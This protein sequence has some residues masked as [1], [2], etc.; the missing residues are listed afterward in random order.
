VIRLLILLALILPASAESGR[1]MTVKATGYCGGPCPICQTTGTT[2]DGS[3]TDA[4][5]Y[6]IAAHLRYL[7]LGTRLLITSGYGYL[8][9][10][11]PDR[12]FTV[13]DTGGL[14][15]HL[16]ESTPDLWI[17]LRFRSHASAR[18]WGVRTISVFVFDQTNN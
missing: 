7:P 6:G 17:D 12:V 10:S 5:P 4:S 16:S 3:A 13:D 1:W 8:D 9:R 2:A 18:A 15:R 11:R 14:I